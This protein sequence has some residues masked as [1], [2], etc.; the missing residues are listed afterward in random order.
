M[1]NKKVSFKI[2]FPLYLIFFSLLLFSTRDYSQVQSSPINISNINRII[3]ILLAFAFVFIFFLK[4]LKIRKLSFLFIL[5]FNYIL[6]SFISIILFSNNF[7]YSFWKLFE[8]LVVFLI[9]V[10][11]WSLS[12]Y[13]EKMAYILYN[14]FLMFFKLLL[15]SV[16]LSIVFFPSMALESASSIG[17]ALISFRVNGVFPV[18]NAISVGTIS[19]IVFFDS[20]IN[21]IFKLNSKKKNLFWMILS[22]ILLITSQSRTSLLGLFAALFLVFLLSKKIKLLWKIFALIFVLIIAIIFNNIIVELFVRGN[23]ENTLIT[24][25]GR[26]YWWNYIWNK[27]LNDNIWHQLFGY[28]YASGV[29]ELAL[30]PSNGLMQ[31]F[32]STYFSSLAATGFIGTFLIFII[33]VYLILSSLKKLNKGLD[34]MMYISNIKVLGITIILFI[35]SFTTD[36][37]NVLTFYLPF[38]FCIVILGKY[39]NEEF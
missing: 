3:G 38:L 26:T 10:Y 15:I 21:Y 30:I 33:F 20:F 6:V 37:I 11:F 14:S 35:K 34:K 2:M 13:F 27:I 9:G 18:I 19:S 28:G 22:F 29:R 7:L 39:K 12:F 32:D 8:I 31:T 16:V 23:N 5:Y 36:T 17:S 24:I 25:S 4:N 1:E